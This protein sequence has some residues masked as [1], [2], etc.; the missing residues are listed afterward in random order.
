MEGIS[1]DQTD[2]ELARNAKVEVF[3]TR[4]GSKYTI[5]ALPIDKADEWTDKANTIDPLKSKISELES[6][7]E[8]GFH[9]GEDAEKL[10][11]L[12]RQYRQKM[13][14]LVFMYDPD[15]IPE[16]KVKEEGVTPAQ[17]ARAFWIMQAIND[18]FMVERKMTMDFMIGRMKGLSTIGGGIQ[19][20]R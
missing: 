9:E 19:A 14:E 1:Y 3:T 6:A 16:Q 8:R 17:L 5:Q 18:P 7:M 15:A 20:R 2:A 13:Y 4:T 12:R 10:I 11:D